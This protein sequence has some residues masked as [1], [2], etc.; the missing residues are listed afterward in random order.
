MSISN[1]LVAIL[2]G[3]LIAAGTATGAQ[4]YYSKNVGVMKHIP[5]GT[6]Q[7]DSNPANLSSLREFR[8]C[9]TEVTTAV[10][11]MVMGYDPRKTDMIG[12]SEPAGEISWNEA[13]SFCNKLS[14]L[15]GLT[16]FYTINPDNP[17][18]YATVSDWSANGYR[19]PTETEWMWAAIGADLENPGDINRTGYLKKFA[20]DTGSNTIDE[21][22]VYKGETAEHT[23]FTPKLPNELGL[24]H[25]S[26]SRWEMCWDLFSANPPE[27]ELFNHTG[28]AA[29]EIKVFAH[30][31][32]GGSVNNTAAECSVLSRIG[33]LYNR[34]GYNMG[35]RVARN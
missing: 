17:N 5:G 30:V 33:V 32:R 22:A 35:F 9:T 31:L 11:A 13:I 4:D 12:L 29:S 27:G 8:L 34:I 25:M 16:P 1:H 26:G 18:N 24:Y 14:V 19:L 6:F 3:G 15:E 10:F 23:C 7:R 21:C 2:A 28:P 20:G